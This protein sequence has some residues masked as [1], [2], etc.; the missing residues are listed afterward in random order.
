MYIYFFIRHA[1]HVAELFYLQSNG[2][3]MEYPAWRKKPPIPQFLTF[4]KLYRLDPSATDENET[5]IRNVSNF[6]AFY[7]H[8]LIA[9]MVCEPKSL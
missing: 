5:S 8:T 2:S 1:E 6:V 3:M 9:Q 7:V 4:Q